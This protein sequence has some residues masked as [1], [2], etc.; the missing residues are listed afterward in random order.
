MPPGHSNP[1]GLQ[2]ERVI[3]YGR[4][5]VGLHGEMVVPGEN[6]PSGLLVDLWPGKWI[7]EGT[8]EN[9]LLLDLL[10]D[11]QARNWC[12]ESYLV[13]PYGCKYISLGLQVECEPE[14][15]AER[16]QGRPYSI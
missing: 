13:F 12:R 3:P 9:M 7:A 16:E 14:D 1:L 4:W 11:L 15:G 5:L 10:R 2:V 8:V 6:R